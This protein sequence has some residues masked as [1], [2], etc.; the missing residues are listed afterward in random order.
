MRFLLLTILFSLPFVTSAAGLEVIV[1]DT[2]ATVYVVPQNETVYTAKAVIAFDETVLSVGNITF[3]PRW[4]QLSQEGYDSF[5]NGQIIKTAGYPK[6]IT[7][8]TALLTFSVTK[9]TSGLG[10]IT[11]EGTSELY[12]ANGANIATSFGGAT[13][14]S[15]VERTAALPPAFAIS[16]TASVEEAQ[17]EELVAAPIEEV[18]RQETLPAAVITIGGALPVVPLAVTLVILLIGLA[19]Y[20]MIRKARHRA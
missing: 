13:I 5:V 16:E 6:G 20:F 18:T 1:E 2:T 8:K 14:G 9:K 12:D 7:Q 17:E 4:M 19:I 3:A 10:V 15:V 11:I